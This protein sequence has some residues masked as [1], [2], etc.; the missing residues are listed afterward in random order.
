M[1]GKVYFEKKPSELGWTPKGIRPFWKPYGRDSS[2][3]FAMDD[4]AAVLD[5]GI[6]VD[7][8]PRVMEIKMLKQVLQG[9]SAAEKQRI[10]LLHQIVFVFFH[11]T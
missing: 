4:R 8:G 5:G 1:S 10:I 3:E 9:G 11:K 6:D 7:C 2:I